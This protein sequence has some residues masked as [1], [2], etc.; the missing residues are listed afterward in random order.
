VSAFIWW[1]STPCP[2][3]PEQQEVNGGPIPGKPIH[4]KGDM[5]Q[6]DW[7]PLFTTPPGA[8]TGRS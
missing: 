5:F 1:A 6:F 8:G 4:G 2:L 3:H 7:E